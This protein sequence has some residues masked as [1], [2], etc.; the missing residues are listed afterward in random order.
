TPGNK[1]RILATLQQGHSFRN[2]GLLISELRKLKQAAPVKPVKIPAK[3][4]LELTP[5]ATPQVQEAAERRQ[6]IH[7]STESY[8][9]RVRFGD[10]PA[11]LRPR[12][13]LLK[14]LFA[15]MVD[16]KFT[17][18]DLPAKAEKDALKIQL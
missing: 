10:L 8:F 12:F 18:N 13:R 7:K 15:D 3:E 5:V 6:L 9:Q 16:L 17:L 1:S 2:M 11:A 14:D 4:K